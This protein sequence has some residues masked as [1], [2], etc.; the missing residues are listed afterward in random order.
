LV[1]RVLVTNGRVLAKHKRYLIKGVVFRNAFLQ[2]RGD[3]ELGVRFTGTNAFLQYRDDLG[4]KVPCS[5]TD[6][7]L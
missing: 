6:A 7:I 5:G 1:K 2:S 3:I 4:S